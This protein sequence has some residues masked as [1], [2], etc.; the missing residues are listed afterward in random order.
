MLDYY[1]RLAWDSFRRTWKLTSLMVVAI[2]L[3]VAMTMTA[4]TVLYVMSRDPIPEKSGQLFSVQI[5]NGGPRSRIVGNNDLPDQM[6]Y[7][8]SLALLNARAGTRQ[9]AMHQLSLTVT[10]SDHRMRPFTIFGRATTADFFTMFDVPVRYGHPWDVTDETR[11]IPVVV[12]SEKLNTRLFGGANSVGRSI[13]LDGGIYQ[14]IGVLGSW[15]PKPR[16]YDVVGGLNFDEGDD[17][18]LP[19]PLSIKQGMGTAEYI[20]CGAGTAGRT[21][22]D[23]LRSECVWLQFWVELPTARDL[24]RY[25]AFLNGYARDQQLSGRFAWPPNTRLLNVREWLVA[26][27]VVPDDAKISVIVAFGF[28]VVCLVSALSLMLAKEFGRAS[29]LGMRRAM[30]ASRRDVFVQVV[31]ESGLVGL[32]GG[33]LGLGLVVASLW[34]MRTVFPAGMARIAHMDGTLVAETILFAIGATLIAGVY[35]AWSS[36]RIAPALQIKGG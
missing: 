6:T 18:Y 26:E 23:L 22:D 32:L 20:S 13:N 24:A 2:A 34:V 35:P 25:R 33:A 16:F 28:F 36:M 12:L 15:D 11:I 5:D 10:P 14:V 17:A 1:L 7:R 9:A 29:Q 27:K 19:L 31:V 30:G 4:Y 3:G 21:W 8:D